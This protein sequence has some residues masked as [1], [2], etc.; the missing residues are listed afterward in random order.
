MSLSRSLVRR[1]REREVTD[2]DLRAAERYLRDWLASAV[3]GRATGP[4]EM[5]LAYGRDGVDLESRVFL[6]AALSHITETDDLHPG[7]TTHPGCVVFPPALLLAREEGKSGPDV[8]E[9]ALAG[10]EVMIRIGEALGPGHYRIF[11]NTA[12]AGVFGAAAAAASVLG[13]GEDAWVWALGSAGTQAAGLWQF[14]DEGAMSKH[15]H[16][17]HAASAG[18]RSALLAARGFTG[19]AEILEGERGFFAGFCPDPEPDAVLRPSDGW[20]LPETSLKPYPCCRHVHPAIDAALELRRELGDVG[21]DTLKAVRISTYDAGRE[22]TDNARPRTPYQAKFSI[23]YCV[24]A[25]LIGGPPE[26]ATFDPGRL[27][28]PG[29]S[30]LLDRTTVEVDEG[31]EAAYP[32]RWGAEVRVDLRDGGE[33]GARRAV[34]RGSPED[35]LDDEAL[36]RKLRS[37]LAHGGLEPEEADDLLDRSRALPGGGAPF[38]IP[39]LP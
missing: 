9:A 4:G 21:P 36:D 6:A 25:A 26:M 16:A 24:A 8:L 19:A 29:I 14:N 10:Y 30:G 28:D 31:L 32:A 5:L 37:L 38:S 2:G 22:R 12:T 3:A 17:G 7:S 35:P 15:L 33:R 23:Q 1:V 11:H 18:L 13:L 34:P 27:D 39:G 20:K